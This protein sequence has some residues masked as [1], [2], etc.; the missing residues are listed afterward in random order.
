M[1]VAQE[2]AAHGIS[3]RRLRTLAANLATAGALCHSH[4][5]GN[6]S[7]WGHDC[8]DSEEAWFPNCDG[9]PAPGW[10]R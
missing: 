9:K 10:D 1:D 6:A 5:L 8:E 4:W 3:M 7:V 2:F